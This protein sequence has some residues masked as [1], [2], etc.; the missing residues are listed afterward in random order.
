[1]KK[2]NKC[3]CTDYEYWDLGIGPMKFIIC[4]CEE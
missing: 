3:E 2:K 1:M 4:D